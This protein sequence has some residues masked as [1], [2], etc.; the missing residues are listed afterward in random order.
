MKWYRCI[1]IK[2]NKDSQTAIHSQTNIRY[3]L[4]R[5]PYPM[6]HILILRM[7]VYFYSNQKVSLLFLHAVSPPSLHSILLG[8]YASKIF[9]TVRNHDLIST[10]HV[11]TWDFDRMQS[12]KVLFRFDFRFFGFSYLS[13]VRCFFS[14]DLLAFPLRCF[15]KLASSDILEGH[16][17]L[18]SRQVW[19]LT[20]SYWSSLVYSMYSVRS[21]PTP[22]LWGKTNYTS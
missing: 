19:P 15:H 13:E 18:Y 12:A 11:P 8:V 17:T 20:V 21:I 4:H 5:Y 9:T 16:F 7:F 3:I 14:R 22:S 2:I 1:C 6:L 10:H